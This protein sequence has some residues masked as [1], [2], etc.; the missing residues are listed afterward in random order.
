MTLE[1]CSDKLSCCGVPSGEVKIDP[2]ECPHCGEK[3]Q[4]VSEETVRHIVRESLADRMEGK[5]FKF[6]KTSDCPMVYYRDG[7]RG[8]PS[9]T[10]EEV[11]VR[12]GL[13]ET[14]DPIWACYCFHVSER[15]IREE[16]ERTG[17]S[18]AS[19]CIRKEVDAGTCECEIKNPS[20]RCCLGEVRAVEKRFLKGFAKKF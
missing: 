11:R 1:N 2:L 10:K 6:C 3:G 4:A 15:M 8:E 18:T 5:S 19:E 9:F 16:I 13:K 7:S 17:R 20:G 12:V 14:E